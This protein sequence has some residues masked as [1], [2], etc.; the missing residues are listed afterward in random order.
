MIGFIYT[1][2]H[3]CIYIS[4]PGNLSILQN[5]SR[6]CKAVPQNALKFVHYV[7]LTVKGTIELPHIIYSFWGAILLDAS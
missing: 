7:L 5:Q 3:I 2:K 4:N 6:V 1:Y